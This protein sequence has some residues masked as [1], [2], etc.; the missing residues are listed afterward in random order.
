MANSAIQY[1]VGSRALVSNSGFT[2]VHTVN[3]HRWLFVES[4]HITNTTNGA[5][6]IELCVV[7]TGGT[8]STA[9]ALLWDHSI[10]ANDFL[11][12]GWS[13]RVPPLGTIKAKGSANNAL[14]IQV[15]GYEAGLEG[16]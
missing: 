2:T 5:V 4:I 3:S 9:N 16:A 6:T 15:T 13:T 14:M 7:P 10:A 11:E 8:A 1:Q 12:F